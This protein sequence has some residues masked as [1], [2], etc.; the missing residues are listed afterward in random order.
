[1]GNFETIEGLRVELA[2]ALG[3]AAGYVDVIDALK[4]EVARLRELRAVVEHH[5]PDG[6]TDLGCA[7]VQAIRNALAKLDAVEYHAQGDPPRAVMDIVR[8]EYAKLDAAPRAPL[9]H[10]WRP[11]SGGW[12]C[13]RC[14]QEWGVGTN[15]PPPPP[16]EPCANQPQTADGPPRETP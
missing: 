8:R 3:R 9:T 15:E 10:D 13:H 6:V 14:G 11:D 4:A 2:Q 16:Q 5:V 12:V 7:G 1:V